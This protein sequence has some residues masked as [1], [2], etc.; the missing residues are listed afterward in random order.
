M[1]GARQDEPAVVDPGPDP[2]QTVAVGDAPWTEPSR[3]STEPNRAL[4]GAAVR[5]VAGLFCWFVLLPAFA[6]ASMLSD[7]IVLGA[8]IVAGIG[9][10]AAAWLVR[11]RPVRAAVGVVLAVVSSYCALL[12]SSVRSVARC[13]W[14][15]WGGR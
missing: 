15:R 8:L 4:T 2:W 12:W 14:S 9:F 6:V 1:C 7:L 5:T 13:I 11:A 3:A 10:V